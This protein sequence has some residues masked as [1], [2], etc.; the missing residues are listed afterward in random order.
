[1]CQ[2][3]AAQ[4]RSLDRHALAN[5]QLRVAGPHFPIGAPGGRNLI[6]AGLGT[7]RRVADHPT[8]FHHR[9]RVGLRQRQ[10]RR[11]E[12]QAHY[13]DFKYSTKSALW[14]AVRPKDFLVL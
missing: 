2:V 6:M 1:M 4:D 11:D 8:I 7:D 3:A 13:R 14:L 10:R 12:W 9:R 5:F